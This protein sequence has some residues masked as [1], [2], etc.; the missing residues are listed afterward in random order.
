MKQGVQMNLVAL[1]RAPPKAQRG[2]ELL[3]HG[4]VLRLARKCTGVCRSLLERVRT[5][6]S[7]ARAQRGRAS[8]LRVVVRVAR[9]Q[10]CLVVGGGAG[11]VA[12][13]TG[14]VAGVLMSCPCGGTGRL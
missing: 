3:A 2:R 6:G 12:G 8:T 1:G 4:R 10:C 13:V 11:V 7:L 9:R 5:L 14:G